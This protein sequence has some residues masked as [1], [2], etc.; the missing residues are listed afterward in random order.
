M[1]TGDTERLSFITTIG[2]ENAP[3]R[4][5]HRYKSEHVI[6]EPDRAHK[7]NRHPFWQTARG[8]FYRAIRGANSP[9]PVL[10]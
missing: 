4:V 9:K 1:S 2:L 5:Y 8:V 6:I 10:V 3:L 7:L